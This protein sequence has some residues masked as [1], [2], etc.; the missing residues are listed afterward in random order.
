MKPI[1]AEPISGSC[2]FQPLDCVFGSR[3]TQGQQFAGDLFE[4]IC[5][6]LAQ[7]KLKLFFL[8]TCVNSLIEKL[9]SQ[10]LVAGFSKVT[11]GYLPNASVRQRSAHL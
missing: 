2:R 1:G 6:R 3:I 8:L 4:S 10:A 11:S 9:S 7:L 5:V